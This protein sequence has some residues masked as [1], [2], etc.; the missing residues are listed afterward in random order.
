LPR[1]VIQQN[2]SVMTFFKIDVRL[3]ETLKPRFGLNN[4]PS[5]C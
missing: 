5:T 1:K 2:G 3:N 4:V